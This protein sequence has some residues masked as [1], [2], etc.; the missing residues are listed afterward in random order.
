MPLENIGPGVRYGVV[1]TGVV[2]DV[3]DDGRGI[4]GLG[5]VI[6]LGDGGTGAYAIAL[7]CQAEVVAAGN[8][9]WERR[10]VRW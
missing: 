10:W 9:W 7:L 1:E 3:L 5:P 2:I 6:D 4:R 8:W